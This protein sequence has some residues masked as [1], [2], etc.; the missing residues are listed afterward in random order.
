M[1]CTYVTKKPR[2][3]Q[4]YNIPN[5]Y[6]KE[7]EVMVS[8]VLLSVLNDIYSLSSGSVAHN[9]TSMDYISVFQTVEGRTGVLRG[10]RSLIK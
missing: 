3:H 10:S 4:L 7:C 5:L 1:L 2:Y 9:V 6:N 8:W